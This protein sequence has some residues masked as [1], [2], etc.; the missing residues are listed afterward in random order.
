MIT[1]ELMR[2][3]IETAQAPCRGK[4]GC[5]HAA[6]AADTRLDIEIEI[7]RILHTLPGREEPALT[8]FYIAMHIGYRLHQL[9]E[10][11]VKKPQTI[12]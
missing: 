9:E 8:L 10:M 11:Q 12:Q 1:A 2:E 7:N 5:I 3:A 6:A 4:N